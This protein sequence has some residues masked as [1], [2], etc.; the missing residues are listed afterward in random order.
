MR[1]IQAGVLEEIPG[2]DSQKIRVYLDSYM[3]FHA[4]FDGTG[5]RLVDKALW[6]LGKFLGENNLPREAHP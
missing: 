5:S 6:S 1:F 2:K 4:Q 3:A